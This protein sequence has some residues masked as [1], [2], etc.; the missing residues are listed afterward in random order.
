MYRRSISLGNQH[1]R[2]IL[3]ETGLPTVGSKSS[4]TNGSQ[5]RSARTTTFTSHCMSPF[6]FCMTRIAP[7]STKRL[8]RAYSGNGKLEFHMSRCIFQI[9]PTRLQRM[10]Y[11]PLSRPPPTSH[12]STSIAVSTCCSSSTV[13]TLRILV[14]KY[15]CASQNFCMAAVPLTKRWCGGMRLPCDVSIDLILAVSLLPKY[16]TNALPLGVTAS[17]TSSRTVFYSFTASVITSPTTK[18]RSNPAVLTQMKQL[19]FHP[20]N[21]NDR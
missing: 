20:S 15:R 16:M 17:R 3:T 1:F 18:I 21:V 2:P 12:C 10:M 13:S 14:S 4:Y 11:F 8:N 7:I 19:I 5:V 9:P 6:P